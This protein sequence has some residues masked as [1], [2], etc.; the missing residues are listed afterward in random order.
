MAQIVGHMR[1]KRAAW[2]DPL[3]HVESFLHA[4]V[5][6]VRPIPQRIDDERVNALDES[7]CLV[8]QAIAI[9]Q[10]CEVPETE[11]QDRHTSMPQR[12][13]HDAD[14]TERKRSVDLVHLELWNTA[15]ETR[16]TVED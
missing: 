6:A 8:V 12:H 5:R 7:P 10:V 11:T 13:G 4:E 9:G 1:G 15:S 2:P 3:N 16:L 14:T